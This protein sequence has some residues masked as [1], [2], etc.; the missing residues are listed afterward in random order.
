M[1]QNINLFSINR[2]LEKH[3]DKVPVIMT[4][5]NDS[6]TNYRFLI[7]NDTTVAQF[8]ST[9]RNKINIDKNTSIYLFIKSDNGDIIVPTSLTFQTVYNQYKNQNN[10]LM[11][12]YAKENIFG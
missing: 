11:I 10:V 2:L 12:S 4:D 7:A 5:N 9:F 8:M 6:K 3:P 1:D